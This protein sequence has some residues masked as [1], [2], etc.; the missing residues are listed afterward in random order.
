M[1]SFVY[2]TFYIFAGI[3]LGQIPSLGFDLGLLGERVNTYVTW[4]YIAKSP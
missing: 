1:N 2:T 4:L 3:S